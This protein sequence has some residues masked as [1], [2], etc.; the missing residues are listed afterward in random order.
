MR[1]IDTTSPASSTR[2]SS[3]RHET[4]VMV[5]AMAC[6]VVL[7]LQS[8]PLTAATFA[9]DDTTD[10]V[11]VVPG[12]GACADA[13]GNCTLRAAIMEANALTGADAIT[14]PAGTY[15]IAIAGT[16]EDACLT[17][18][19]D[20]TDTTGQLTITGAG[21]DATYIDA[22][23]LDRVFDIIDG[24]SLAV[25]QTTVRN[26]GVVASGAGFNNRGPSILDLEDVVMTGASNYPGEGGGFT[27][28]G[29][30]VTATRVSI[31][32]N[33]SAFYPGFYNR[34]SSGWIA[35]V[36]MVDS[37]I[38]NNYGQDTGWVAILNSGSNSPDKAVLTMTNCT[39]S[40]NTGNTPRRIAIKNANGGLLNLNN[41]TITNNSALGIENATADALNVGGKVYIKNSILA[42]NTGFGDCEGTYQSEGHNLIQD[43]A[44]GPCT[45]TGDT[46]GNIIGSPPL[47][48]P[49]TD[50]GGPTLTHLPL[51][52]SPAIDA[53]NPA[54][55]GSG[56]NACVADDQRGI[57]RPQDGDG[58][59]TALCDMGAVEIEPPPLYPD[60]SL[61]KD[62]YLVSVV[63]GD[64]IPYSLSFT[65]TGNGDAYGVVI[66]ETVPAGT[67]FNAAAS[68][69]TWVCL[70]DIN[71]GS[72]CTLG[73]VDLIVG[74]ADTVIFGVTVN[75][76]V[77]SGVTQ[78]AN[79][80]SIADDGTGGVDPT[81]GD[82]NDSDTTTVSAF[83]DFA[84]DKDDG[85]ASPAPGDTVV[86]TLNFANNGNQGAEGVVLSETVPTHTV[87]DP[88][89]SSPG[90]SCTPDN[91]AG[92]DCTYTAGSLPG[93]G[94][95]GVADFAVIIDNPTPP[96][97][98][99]I[100]NTAS[101]TDDWLNGSDLNPTDNTDTVNTLFETVPPTVADVGTYNDTGDGSLYDCES[102]SGISVVR[103]M[104]TFSEPVRDPPGD[105]DPDDVT[106]PANYVVVGTGLD[107]ELDTAAC[108]AVLGDDIETT[109]TGVDY[110]PGTNTSTIHLDAALEASVYRLLVC[111]STSIL[112]LAGNP[113]D[114]DADGNGGDD[115]VLTFRADPV[116]LFD[117]GHLD[118]GM[119]LWTITETIP[120]AIT[121]STVDADDSTLSGS[122]LV[123]NPTASG[124]AESYSLGQCVAIGGSHPSMVSRAV[125]IDADPGITLT[126]V[127]EWEYFNTD[128]CSGSSL[129]I[130]RSNSV[131]QDTSGAWQHIQ[132]DSTAPEA[133]VSTMCRSILETA[134]GSVFDAW[135]DQLEMTNRSAVFAD[136]FESGNSNA[137]SDQFP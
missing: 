117:N 74:V 69:V 129:S 65:N 52:L 100:S 104:V 82:N 118:C 57:V 122:A 51:E 35:T 75:N 8:V 63:P 114:G 95:T 85:G 103:L 120:F 83:P 105:T 54:V 137:W 107:F 23:Y 81:P 10:T 131:T 21:I 94:A 133:A 25:K 48:G 97:V 42:G 73:P 89:S 121:A 46:T 91:Q 115:F 127:T 29:G 112:D 116:N 27:N 34:G 13:S 44:T 93:G 98:S 86:Y 17:G 80:A 20:V 136:G 5:A 106:N 32:G 36:T 30:T 110:E 76:P 72:T 58:N 37:S 67:T 134:D 16:G 71:A 62:D 50:N 55:P 109:I 7:A 45:I 96:G 15:T 2:P 68:T 31:F 39:V 84:I 124:A 130:S 78:I 40:G 132:H 101:I 90:W 56:G 111:G 9:V 135:I 47:L 119:G 28:N 77:A 64:T 61:T 12:D 53:A 33:T 88:A 3:T 113:L 70:P 128:D 43:I 125:R 59:A 87:F 22:N 102:A 123:S 18:D 1:W 19:F 11:D 14:L 6:L 108:G 99:H 60:L 66:T 24:A 38:V 92:S 41:V 126:I 4:R 49:L 26:G 79:T